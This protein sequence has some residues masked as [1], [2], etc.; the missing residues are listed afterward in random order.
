MA[1][2]RVDIVQIKMVKESS[3][4]YATR[5]IQSA[6]EAA[7]LVRDFIGDLD[8]EAMVVIA[9]NAKY[10]PNYLNTI[11]IGSLTSSIVHPREVFKAAI[12]GNAHS[13]L[14][15]HNHPSGNTE[16]S[17]EDISITRRLKK[18]SEVLGIPITDHLIISDKDHYSFRENG[19]L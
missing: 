19:Y 8:R 11:S 16:P 17:Q 4:L 3:I 13:I 18:A 7:K 9:L 2:K 10:E 14:L 1:A 5:R 6:I 15:A 12:L